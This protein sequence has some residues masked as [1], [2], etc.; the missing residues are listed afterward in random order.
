MSICNIFYTYM[1]FE[2]I[3]VN[4]IDEGVKMHLKKGNRIFHEAMRLGITTMGEFGR[5]INQ[6]RLKVKRKSL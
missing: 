5:F 6:E 2:D 3:I 4:K 1:Q